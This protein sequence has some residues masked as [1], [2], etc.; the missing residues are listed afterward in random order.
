MGHPVVYETGASAGEG[1]DSG[2]LSASGQ[3]ADRCT[4]RSATADNGKGFL[5][6]TAP[7]HHATYSP[8]TVAAGDRGVLRLGRSV[9]NR[10]GVSHWRS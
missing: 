3:C 9:S 10:V 7:Y 4:T 5:S 1:S 6:A 8:S 2:A